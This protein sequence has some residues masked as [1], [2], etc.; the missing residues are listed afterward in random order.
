MKLTLELLVW[1]GS[2]ANE[3]TSCIY[4]NWLSPDPVPGDR[5]YSQAHPFAHGVWTA[6]IPT[7]ELGHVHFV[8]R[9]GNVSVV[10]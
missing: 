5:H 6:P 2:T 10:W 7:A 9:M 1:G 3:E 4:K 8:V